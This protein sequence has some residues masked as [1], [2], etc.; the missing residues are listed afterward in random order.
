MSPT[1]PNSRPLPQ[2]MGPTQAPSEVIIN[3]T[4][5]TPDLDPWALRSMQ[6]CVRRLDEL[7]NLA[8]GLIVLVSEDARQAVA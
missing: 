8:P 3:G 7:R 5:T 2:D 1:P 6:I 4:R